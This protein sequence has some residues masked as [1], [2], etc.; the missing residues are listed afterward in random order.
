[1]GYDFQVGLQ[2]FTG[3]WTTWPIWGRLPHP[4]S[5]ATYYAIFPFPLIFVAG[6]GDLLV[7]TEPLGNPVDFLRLAPTQRKEGSL[8]IASTTSQIY[9]HQ[10][11]LQLL[12]CRYSW[13]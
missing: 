9:T 7:D 3:K 1:M 11:K 4:D 10:G 6:F 13:E 12:I 5:Q 2:V 8:L